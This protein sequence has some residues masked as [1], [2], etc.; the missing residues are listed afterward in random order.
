MFYFRGT[1]KPDFSNVEKID[2]DEYWQTRGFTMRGKLME[3]EE[4]FFRW[5]LE[6]SKVLDIGCGN[7]RLLWELQR[8]KHCQCTGIDRSAVVLAGQKQAGIKV[9][10]ADIEEPEFGLTERY[11][12]IILSEVLEHLRQ[13]E[14]LIKKS[15]PHTKNFALSVPNSAFYRYRVG[16]MFSGRFFTQWRQHPSEHLRF[17]SHIDFLD[18]LK[19]LR[20]DVT[21]CAASNGF[22]L[23]NLWPNMF[24]HQIC[25]LAKTGKL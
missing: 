12:Y 13:P 20:L 3:R 16:L 21:T 1:R 4:I 17:W 25:Y 8:K 9:Y 22:W 19:A 14:D 2:Y 10:S 5:I 6:G 18:W 24:G 15:T 11:D 23:K 7:S